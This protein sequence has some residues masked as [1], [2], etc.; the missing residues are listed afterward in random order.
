LTAQEQA[1]KNA[2]AN[3]VKSAFANAGKNAGANG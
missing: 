2:G 1:G 3:G